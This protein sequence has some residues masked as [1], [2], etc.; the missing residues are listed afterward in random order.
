LIGGEKG[1]KLTLEKGDVI[2]IPAG[3]AHKNLTP[4][5]LFKCVGAYPDGRAYDIQYGKKGER[6]GADDQ[7]KQVPIP[8]LDP[9]LGQK[10]TMHQYWK[11]DRK[12]SWK[13]HG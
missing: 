10:G 9:V 11:E 3:V 4:R 13:Q 2:L 12:M 6:P 1:Y 5:K 8:L 7:I